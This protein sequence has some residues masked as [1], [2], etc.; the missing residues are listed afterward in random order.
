MPNL[1]QSEK[2]ILG[3]LLRETLEVPDF[4]RSYSWDAS[5]V[6]SFWEDINAFSNRYPDANL[7]N[8]EYFVGPVVL[9]KSNADS[10][11][12]LDGQ[13]R[14]ATS[15]ILLSVVADHLRR[16][17]NTDAATRIQENHIAGY[18][19][20]RATHIYHL[21]LNQYDREFFRREVQEPRADATYTPPVPTL[22]S[23]KLIRATRDYFLGCIGRKQTEFGADT[24]GFIRWLIR[25]NEVL[26]NHVSVVYVSSDNEDNAA[27]VFETLNDRGIGLSAPDL[28]RNLLL[29]RATPDQREGIVENWKEILQ[30]ESKA[31]VEDFLR[32]YWLSREGDVKTRSLYREIKAKVLADDID[33]AELTRGL[34][35]EASVYEHIVNAEDDDPQLKD[36]L[37]AIKMLGAKSALPAILSAYA[38]GNLNQKRVFL[39]DLVALH[40]R[41]STIGGLENN[42]IESLLFSIAHDLRENQD[43]ATAKTRMRTLAPTDDIF[44]ARFE[45]AQV[46]K[47]SAARYLLRKL[48][49]VNRVGTGEIEV[50]TDTLRV[51]LEHIYPQNP[52]HGRLPEHDNIVHRIGNLSLLAR[53]LNT[54][55]KNADFDTKKLI[56]AG[57]DFVTTQALATE[58]S[59][60]ETEIAARQAGF[61]VQAVDIWSLD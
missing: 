28:L 2:K 55:Q 47:G 45:T 5:R 52:A 13:Q 8:Q 1:Y 10:A 14:V 58:D 32:H 29:S 50:V 30:I 24:A 48:E 4:Q 51:N 9:V 25:I 60:T 19:D 22:E 36:S 43:F 57:S 37:G 39:K 34:Q 59:W 20:Y 26:T 7:A 16:L 12:I 49:E 53:K 3:D 54:E 23:H 42:R 33:S 38:V 6:E 61:A 56:Y 18:S 27:L 15:T 21:T 11:L 46:T 40:V 35:E 44:R 41:Y 31:S 17:G